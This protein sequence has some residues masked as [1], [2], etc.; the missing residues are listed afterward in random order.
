MLVVE[1]ILRGALGMPSGPWIASSHSRRR[2]GQASLDRKSEQT[3][4]SHKGLTTR[5]SGE[6]QPAF[7]Q[8]ASDRP[9]VTSIKL[10]RLEPLLACHRS[11]PQ[12]WPSLE[13][14]GSGPG[15]VRTR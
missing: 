3:A 4:D 12:G 9:R 7:R 15:R 1:N 11:R 14:A 8:G 2:P 5:E 10:Y 6:Q 13:A